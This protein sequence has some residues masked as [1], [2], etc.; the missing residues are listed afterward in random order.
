MIGKGPKPPPPLAGR[1][2][3][4]LGAEAEKEEKREGAPGLLP[5]RG[6]GL[7]ARPSQGAWGAGTAGRQAGQ[8]CGLRSGHFSQSALLIQGGI[9]CPGVREPGLKRGEA[10]PRALGRF[11]REDSL[12]P[13]SRLL[14]P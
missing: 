1:P 4:R 9:V 5:G 6:G 2:V 12:P 13:C 10:E 7:R 11:N 14:S 3:S 8:G